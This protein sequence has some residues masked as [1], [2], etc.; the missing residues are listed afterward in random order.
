MKKDVRKS[1]PSKWQTAVLHWL[2]LRVR[3]H[4]CIYYILGHPGLSMA[5]LQLDIPLKQV[6]YDTLTLLCSPPFA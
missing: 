1:K 2:A 3:M 6:K 5:V 4:G